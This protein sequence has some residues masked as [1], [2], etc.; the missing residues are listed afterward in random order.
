MII[1]RNGGRN[2]RKKMGQKDQIPYYRC[3]APMLKLRKLYPWKYIE[4]KGLVMELDEQGFRKF[5]EVICLLGDGESYEVRRAEGG[6][7]EGGSACAGAPDLP[8]SKTG[9]LGYRRSS[10]GCP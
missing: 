9:F 6:A 5:V 1:G 4:G 8:K 3:L 10:G 7:H 2:I